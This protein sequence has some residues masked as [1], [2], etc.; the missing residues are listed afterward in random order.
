MPRAT[1]HAVK[2]LLFLA[3]STA[4]FEPCSPWF[5]GLADDG[6]IVAGIVGH[7][8]RDRSKTKYP[9]GEVLF[10]PFQSDPGIKQTIGEVFGDIHLG[11]EAT[12]LTEGGE[13]VT[14]GVRCNAGLV[15]TC[16][17]FSTIPSL[18]IAAHTGKPLLYHKDRMFEIDSPEELLEKKFCDY[19]DTIVTP[20]LEVQ[21][22][23]VR[24]FPTRKPVRILY[25]NVKSFVSICERTVHRE[26]LPILALK[27][28]QVARKALQTNSEDKLTALHHL[29]M[30]IEALNCMEGI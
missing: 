18:L 19:L 24:A 10:L 6:W 3:K 14:A 12:S 11:A 15:M 22:E 23:C 9:F 25:D 27:A 1:S 16:D 2:S 17:A 26:H 21:R 5:K 28:A 8:S 30:H 7:E 29:Q 13:F 20:D 4:A